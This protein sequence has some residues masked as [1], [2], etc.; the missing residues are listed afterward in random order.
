MPWYRVTFAKA[1][2]CAAPATVVH[3]CKLDDARSV[4]VLPGSWVVMLPRP[5]LRELAESYVEETDK[6]ILTKLDKIWPG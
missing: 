1:S 6:A 3:C 4:V 2:T 5:L